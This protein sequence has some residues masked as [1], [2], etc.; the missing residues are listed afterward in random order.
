[1]TYNFWQTLNNILTLHRHMHVVSSSWYCLKSWSAQI[2]TSV[3]SQFYFY[4]G[5]D[6]IL[7]TKC[8]C[9]CDKLQE[10]MSL[11]LWRTCA[12]VYDNEQDIKWKS[13]W[14]TD[15]MPNV[16]ILDLFH[17]HGVHCILYNAAIHI[18]YNEKELH[19]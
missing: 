18:I 5:W 7:S 13:G 11:Y 10:N 16:A 17:L 15:A 3:N 14:H 19:K 4:T 6:K 2:L 9:F 12:I 1:M 8:K